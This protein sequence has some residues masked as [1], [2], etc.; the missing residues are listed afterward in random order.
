TSGVFTVSNL[1][2][3]TY[4]LKA[5][6]PGFATH[7][8][9]GLVLSAN[10]V[11]NVNVHL[12]VGH[13]NTVVRVNALA[14]A[15]ST[16]TTNISNV[17]TARDFAQLPSVSRQ[18]GDAGYTGFALMN[19]GITSAS[20]NALLNVPGIMQSSVLPTIDGIATTAN[21]SNIGATPIQPGLDAIQEMNV[22]LAN[23]PA[24]F[25][26]PANISMVTKSGT[27]KF[28]GALF[29]S[30]NGNS[31]N[32][33][34]YFAKSVPFRRF[35]NFGAHVGGPIRKEKTFFFADYE[36]ARESVIGI[37][38]LNTP[39]P[40]W[41][42]GDFSGISKPV[43]DPTTGN[44][45]FQNQ[46]PSN[47]ISL[48]SQKI[49]DFFYPL[50]NIGAPGQ[51]SGNF[52]ATGPDSTGFTNYD[53]YDGRV[54]QNFRNGADRVSAHVNYRRMPI[55][56]LDAAL[57]PLGPRPQIRTA[58]NGVISW[59]HQ[60][61]SSILNEARYGY[62]RQRNRYHTT[63]IGSDAIQQIGLQ[64]VDTMALF[65]SPAFTIT[66]LT[67]TNVPNPNN[68]SLETDFEWTDNVSWDR[69]RHAMKFGIDLI[70][71]QI[72]G[73]QYS[74]TMYGS[75]SFTGIYTGNPY[76]DFLL[77]IPQTTS[78]TVPNLARHERGFQLS[79]YAQDTFKVTPNLTVN[80]GLRW[81]PGSPYHDRYGT[82][83]NFDPATDGWGV[84]DA[85]LDRL[86]P[87]YP[88]TIPVAAA[89]TLGFPKSALVESRKLN[90][91]PRI[92][93]AYQPFNKTVI[94]AAYGI[95]GDVIYG[96]LVRSLEGGPFTG[97]VSYFNKITNGVPLF[98]FPDPFLP[99][100]STASQNAF[101]INPRLRTPYTQQW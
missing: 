27:N 2:V 54:D 49:Q 47:R 36:G 48:V 43:I 11:L 62:T 100:G 79:A 72:G 32:A 14:T 59:T 70:R 21:E 74:N 40:P 53:N 6:A 16:Q 63:L 22:Q 96:G 29:E 55:I 13:A 34:N 101:G 75:Y 51:Q 77:G 52:Q 86:N 30:Y 33:R 73:Q 57:P 76:A 88:A 17:K 64:G 60:F 20:G 25:S 82:I 39:L 3:G 90:F 80:Y 94:R 23:T 67:S 44:P 65:G 28:H 1:S 41:R 85:G 42:T 83:A 61:S 38:N 81:Q 45:F 56:S 95:Y 98:S 26:T 87:L 97:S 4:H 84:P 24:E 69:G 66:G 19:P 10:Q 93:I 46:I 71:D 35:N 50:P 91:Y 37:Q 12:T 5:S 92:G 15:I 68:L 9:S 18:S 8:T 78:L 99:T 58:E 7:E 89:S 31:L